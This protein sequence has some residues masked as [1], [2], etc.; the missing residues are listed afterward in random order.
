MGS[1]STSIL[2]RIHRHSFSNLW[3]GGKKEKGGISSNY[4]K[5]YS[6]KAL[7]TA[8]QREQDTSISKQQ[9]FQ[10]HSS[11]TVPM[12]PSLGRHLHVMLQLCRRVPSLNTVLINRRNFSAFRAKLPASTAWT[13]VGK[14]IFLLGF[15]WMLTSAAVCSELPT[16][17]A[18]SRTWPSHPELL[19]YYF[20][21]AVFVTCLQVIKPFWATEWAAVVILRAVSRNRVETSTA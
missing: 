19:N 12:A 8:Q 16:L 5:G 10:T 6:G 15:S 20:S 11:Q 13:E 17:T 3:G 9:M 1:F 21:P 4:R 14:S 7:G 18:L 2:F